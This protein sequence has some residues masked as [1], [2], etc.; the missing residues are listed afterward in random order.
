MKVF[1]GIFFCVLFSL[2][3]LLSKVRPIVMMMVRMV[4]REN[5]WIMVGTWSRIFIEPDSSSVN[6][7]WL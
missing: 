7:D 6:S 3:L 2:S 1:G 4:K 5:D